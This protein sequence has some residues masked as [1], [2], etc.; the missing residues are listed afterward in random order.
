MAPHV[1]HVSLESE[2]SALRISHTIVLSVLRS[3]HMS[4]WSSV[5]FWSP[6]QMVKMKDK[7]KIK[8]YYVYKIQQPLNNLLPCTLFIVLSIS[9]KAKIYFLSSILSPFLLFFFLMFIHLL[10]QY[11]FLYPDMGIFKWSNFIPAFKVLECSRKFVYC[12]WGQQMVW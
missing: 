9:N 5:K 7:K 11:F 8:K 6:E 4:T 12:G 1:G 10:S 3:I 2:P